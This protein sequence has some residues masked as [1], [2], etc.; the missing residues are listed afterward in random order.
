MAEIVEVKVNTKTKQLQLIGALGVGKLQEKT[1]AATEKE[2]VIT[3]DYNYYGL[4]SVTVEAIEVLPV[5]E[6]AVF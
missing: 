3:A 6:M 2:Q 1:V 5:A 4:K